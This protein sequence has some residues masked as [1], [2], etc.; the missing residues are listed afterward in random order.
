[1]GE[2]SDAYRDLVGECK[3]NKQLERPRR[4][5]KDNIKSDIQEIRQNPV[6]CTCCNEASGS[7]K[8]GEFLDYL[9]NYKVFKKDFAPCS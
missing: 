2:W 5:W 4:G 3:V 9:R 1:M 7:I 8:G 6:S